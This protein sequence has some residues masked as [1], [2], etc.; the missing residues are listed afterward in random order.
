MAKTGAT[1]KCFVFAQTKKSRYGSIGCTAFKEVATKGLLL[2][3]N[4]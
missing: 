4:R 1:K 3:A 2:T